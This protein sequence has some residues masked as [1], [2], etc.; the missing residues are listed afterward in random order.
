MTARQYRAYDGSGS[1]SF[2]YKGVEGAGSAGDP[3]S[4]WMVVK[5]GAAMGNIA[6]TP[7]KDGDLFQTLHYIANN[8]GTG[9][10]STAAYSE[11]IAI[12][13]VSIGTTLT[14]LLDV[15]TADWQRLSIRLSNTGAI[16]NDLQIQGF[17]CAGFPYDYALLAGTAIANSYGSGTAKQS[18]NQWIPI[19]DTS[20]TLPLLP[21]AQKAGVII[22]VENYQRIRLQASVASG[23][24]SID[25]S[26]TLMR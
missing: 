6:S 7:D 20:G 22:N 8:L 21:D 1:P 9:G 18:G 12:S 19:I 10:G 2:Y 17:E 14:T 11:A 13:T 25:I 3:E 26:A 16:L 4:S 24:T 5:E 15:T 23:T